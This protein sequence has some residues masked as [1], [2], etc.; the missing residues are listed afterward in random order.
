MEDY[1]DGLIAPEIGAWSEHEKYK[2]MSGYASIFV[3]GMRGKWDQL[4]YIDLFSGAGKSTIRGE[5]RVV[6]GSPLLALTQKNPFDRLVFCEKDGERYSALSERVRALDAS[7]KVR[8]INGDANECTESII[9]SVPKGSKSNRVLSFCFV[10]PCNLSNLNFSTIRTIAEQLIVD[11]MMLVPSGMDANRNIRNLLSPSD[12][13]VSNFTGAMDWR[14]KW[15]NG[16]RKDFRRF[17]VDLLGE[18]MKQLKFHYNPIE[19]PSVVRSDKKNLYL[20]DLVFFSRNKLG[21]KF[22]EA[23]KSASSQQRKLFSV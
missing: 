20:Y 19:N 18:S 14:D 22:W 4:V 6:Y 12:S 11:F 16:E 2:L 9:A 1:D 7:D 21:V 15:N 3:N 8:L 13:L 5:G 23:S 10:D 17:V